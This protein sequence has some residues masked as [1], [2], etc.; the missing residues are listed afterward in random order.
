MHMKRR[1]LKWVLEEADSLE[2][3]LPWER[4]AKRILWHRHLDEDVVVNMPARA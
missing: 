2:V 4:G 1:W 3:T